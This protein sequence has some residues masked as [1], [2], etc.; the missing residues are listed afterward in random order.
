MIRNTI[1][2]CFF[3]YFPWHR[4]VWNDNINT[5]MNPLNHSGYTYHLP[6]IK[7]LRLFTIHSYIWRI[8]RYLRTKT[9][10]S[11]VQIFNHFLFVSENQ[12]F[13]WGVRTEYLNI[14]LGNSALQRVTQ[15]T[16]EVVDW[17][18][19]TQDAPLSGFCMHKKVQILQKSEKFMTS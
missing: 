8:S 9:A 13:Q 2:F 14:I 4:N 19:P 18:H 15:I 10:L 12:C 11:S 3:L 1:L 6:D 5:N 17:I 16:Y 7:R